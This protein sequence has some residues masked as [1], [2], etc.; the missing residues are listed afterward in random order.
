MAKSD[1][2]IIGNKEAVEFLES[3][4]ACER[5]SPG[6][7]GGVYLVSGPSQVGRTSSVEYFI[8]KLLGSDGQH[9]GETID[10]WPDVFRLRKLEDKHEIGVEQAREFS[11]RLA[12]SSFTDSYRVGIIHEAEALSL[13]A[14]NALLKSLEE[15][16]D[17]VI[18][19]LISEQSDLLPATIVSRSQQIIFHPVASEEVYN[20]LVEEHG[21]DRP[22]ANNI[23]RLSLG[24][25]GLALAMAR[26]KNLLEIYLEPARVFVS[27]FRKRLAERFKENS[28]L[29]SQYKGAAAYDAAQQIINS[30]RGVVRDVMLMLLNQPELMR[31]GF[32]EHDIRLLSKNINLAEARRLEN[33]LDQARRYLRANV[34]PNNVLENILISL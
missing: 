22:L 19:F 21:F 32:L 16:H 9:P 5:T 28:A 23:V 14:A 33:L 31:Y 25:P 10:I 8:K 1:W 12:L 29:L 2:P 30:W 26:D 7:I 4:L 34:S 20:W 13:E 3:L 17:K 18:V 27:A 6:S 24:R 11:S 15:A